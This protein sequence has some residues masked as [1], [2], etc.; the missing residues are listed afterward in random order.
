MVAVKAADVDAF[1]AR[2]DPARPVVLVFGPDAGLVSERVVALI[3]TS[4][5]DPN[6]PFALAR[7]EGEDLSAEPTRLVEE[8]TTI[9]LFGGRRAVW[10]KAGSR[11]VAPAVEAVLGAD[12]RDC[13]VVIEAGDLRRN[14]PLRALCERAKNAAALPCYADT[15]R[16][17]IRLIDEEM[18]A[19]GLTLAPDARA[20]L[21]PLL[22]ADRAASRNEIRKLTLYARGGDDKRVSVDDVIAV[23]SDASALALE[24]I[25][26]TAFAGRPIEL[27]AQLAKARTAGSSA[28]SILFNAQGQVAQLHKWRTTIEDGGSFSLDS[29]QPPLHFRRKTLVEAGLKTWNAARLLNAMAELADATLQ[30]RRNSDLADTIAERALLAIAANARRGAA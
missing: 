23:V 1:V 2:P 29:V 26:D 3:K 25:V 24:D 17:R 19:A 16:D 20:L 28:G 5:D 9:P 10:L 8:A 15:E 21:I 7:L 14:S 27:E 6:D 11:N 12:I 4:V 22:G 30:S 18:R 13:R